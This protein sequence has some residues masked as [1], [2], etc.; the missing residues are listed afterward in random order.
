MST[1][2]NIFFFCIFFFVFYAVE[3][4]IGSYL[5]FCWVM[6]MEC[7]VGLRF[8]WLRE[9]WFIRWV[10]EEFDVFCDWVFCGCFVVVGGG[11]LSWCVD[12]PAHTDL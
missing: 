8:L 1:I 2:I 10:V 4:F 12:K 7:G 11:F 6:G 5:V 9:W 3:C